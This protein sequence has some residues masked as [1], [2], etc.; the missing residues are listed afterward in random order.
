M[1]TLLFSGYLGLFLSWFRSPKLEA[2]YLFTFS[3]EV[4]NYWNYAATPPYAF[5]ACI[6]TTVFTYTKVNCMLLF[7]N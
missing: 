5:M 4:M 7:P 2:V 1:W 6:V 3:T